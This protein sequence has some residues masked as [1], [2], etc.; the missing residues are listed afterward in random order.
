MG[1]DR[2]CAA[3]AAQAKYGRGDDGRERAVIVVD[4]GT[5]VNYEVVIGGVYRGGAIAPGPVLSASA[6]AWGTAKLSEI[7]LATP[8]KAV[9]DN[10]E[11]AIRS[12]VVFG[13]IDSVSGM[14]RRLIGETDGEVVVI[15]TGGCAGILR[16]RVDAINIVDDTLVLEGIRL[17][18]Q[19]A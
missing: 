2:L 3:A 11:D 17:L 19:S 5:A 8:K 13:F 15:A 14:L 6:L 12:G 4:A 9:G 10:T 7:D 18:A 16:D 1:V